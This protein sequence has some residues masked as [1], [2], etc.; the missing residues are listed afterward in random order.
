V[1]ELPTIGIIYSKSIAIFTYKAEKIHFTQALPNLSPSVLLLRANAS[2]VT[3]EDLLK[4]VN[5][6]L[7]LFY[8]G[9]VLI[10]SPHSKK[11][12]FERYSK[13]RVFWSEG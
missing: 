8:L 6:P 7:Q 2:L 12:L 5:E 4:K 3:S 11:D 10:A 9:T 1:L 13:K